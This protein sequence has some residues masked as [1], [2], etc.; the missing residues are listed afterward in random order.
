MGVR[1]Q[2]KMTPR[3][4]VLVEGLDPCHRL[5]WRAIDLEDCDSFFKDYD[6]SLPIPDPATRAKA[7]EDPSFSTPR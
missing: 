1:I 6:L 2:F 7:A 3:F 4:G 5:C